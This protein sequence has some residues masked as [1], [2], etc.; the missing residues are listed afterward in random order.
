MDR[1]IREGLATGMDLEGIRDG[2]YTDSYREALQLYSPENIR[3]CC[4]LLVKRSTE[5]VEAVR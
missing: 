5:A 4:R 3:E 2:V 1:R